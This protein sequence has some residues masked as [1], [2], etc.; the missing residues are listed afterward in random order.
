MTF[1]AHIEECF[2]T[3]PLASIS[4]MP[5][6]KVFRGELVSQQDDAHLAHVHTDR[7]Q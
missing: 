6:A 2:F 7:F 3:W 1:S 5:M 4:V